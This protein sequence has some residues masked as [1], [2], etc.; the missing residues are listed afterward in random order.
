[1]IGTQNNFW[2]NS[3]EQYLVGYKI[4]GTTYRNDLENNKKNKFFLDIKNNLI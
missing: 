1:V 2:E 3:A 4:D